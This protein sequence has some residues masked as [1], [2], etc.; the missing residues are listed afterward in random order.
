MDTL[1]KVFLGIAL[2]IFCFWLGWF[3]TD[4]TKNI[5]GDIQFKIKGS[6]SAS[7]IVNGG[8]V[9]KFAVESSS[10][11][12]QTKINLNVINR[13]PNEGPDISFFWQKSVWGSYGIACG[14]PKINT[15]SHTIDVNFYVTPQK[16]VT[17]LKKDVATQEINKF[18]IMCL[19]KITNSADIQSPE[20]MQLYDYLDSKY[21]GSQFFEI[22]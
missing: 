20:F 15:S 18:F 3:I 16:L 10:G 21:G 17:A 8:L 13:F 2:I 14:K 5:A 9:E 4:D 7:L 22:L 19:L 1:K 6:K 11:S 12:G